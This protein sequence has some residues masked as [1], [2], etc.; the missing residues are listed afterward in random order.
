MKRLNLHY[1]DIVQYMPK[2]YTQKH[3][4]E[5]IA[6]ADKLRELGFN[7]EAVL[8]LTKITSANKISNQHF[9]PIQSDHF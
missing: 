8:V 6:A 2:H 1:T 9:I 5:M 4:D 3:K 7:D